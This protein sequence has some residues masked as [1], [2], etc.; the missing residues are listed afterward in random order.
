MYFYENIHIRETD[1]NKNNLN[2]NKYIYCASA[3]EQLCFTK[4]Y[5]VFGLQHIEHT[6]R[7]RGLLRVFFSFFLWQ[8]SRKLPQIVAYASLNGGAK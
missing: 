5:N 8:Q 6:E 7:R 1:K 3:F 2:L 4:L